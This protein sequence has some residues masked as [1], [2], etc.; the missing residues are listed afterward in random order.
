MKRYVLGKWDKVQLGRELRERER[1]KYQQPLGKYTT[2]LGEILTY[3][4]IHAM[5]LRDI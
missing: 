1:E 4:Y 3:L 5:K 2:R